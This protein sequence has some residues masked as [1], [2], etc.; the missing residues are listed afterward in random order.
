NQITLALVRHKI[1]GLQQAAERHIRTQY[2]AYYTR[3]EAKRNAD[4]A[5]LLDD[6]ERFD[7]GTRAH[8]QARLTEI[9]GEQ[10]QLFEDSTIRGRR[11]RIE[12]QLKMHEL[13]MH[14]RRQEVENMRLGT[15]PAPE[16]LNM[17]VVT[18]V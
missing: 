10:K 14:E 16:L 18:P 15:F 7:H 17:V 13:R 11:T 1:S 2:Q 4:I 6:L 9:G 8:L 3:V 12:N 5:V